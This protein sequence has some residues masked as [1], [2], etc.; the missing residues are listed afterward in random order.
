L[1][2]IPVEA[3]VRGY[4][5]GSAF[6]EYSKSCTVHGIKMP[7]GMILN[8]KFP[9]PIYT[10]STKATQGHDENVHPDVVVGMIGKDL[11]QKVEEMALKV[12]SRA[13]EFALERG[14]IIA[15]SKFEFGVDEDGNVVLA[16]EVLTP[17]S[18]RFWD[19]SAYKIG[20]DQD[21]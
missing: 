12:Y 5:T 18:S 9:K 2:I 20:V 4:L 13:A 16:D 10:P 11:A 3:I 7:P 1:K 6:Q 17:D 15:D 8:E 14:I 19:A 21:R